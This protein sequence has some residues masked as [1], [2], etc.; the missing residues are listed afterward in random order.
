L[1]YKTNKNKY[2]RLYNILESDLNNIENYELLKTTDDCENASSKITANEYGLLKENDQLFNNIDTEYKMAGKPQSRMKKYY[3]EKKK[4]RKCPAN[5]YKHPDITQLTNTNEIDINELRHGWNSKKYKDK[6]YS[7]NENICRRK[8]TSLENTLSMEDNYSEVIKVDWNSGQLEKQ[9]RSPLWDNGWKIERD[10][11]NNEYL[12]RPD[13]EVFIN[14]GDIVYNLVK[15]ESVKSQEDDEKLKKL[16]FF[17]HELYPIKIPNN[18]EYNLNEIYDKSDE[19]ILDEDYIKYTFISR[20]NFSFETLKCIDNFKIFKKQESISNEFKHTCIPILWFYKI[21][22]NYNNLTDEKENKFYHLDKLFHKKLM[23]ELLLILKRF[24]L[25][26]NN[27]DDE[28]LSFFIIL[29]ALQFITTNIRTNKKHISLIDSKYWLHTKGEPKFSLFD[30]YYKLNYLINDELKKNKE[31]RDLK[32]NVLVGQIPYIFENIVPYWLNKK[33][34]WEWYEINQKAWEK[35]QLFFSLLQ[36][37]PL[38]QPL[39]MRKFP[40]IFP[41]PKPIEISP[42]DKLIYE[43]EEKI[44]FYERKKHVETHG[45]NSPF[46][47]E[48]KDII[49]KK[50]FEADIDFSQILPKD[51]KKKFGTECA[52]SFTTSVIDKTKLQ[53]VQD[54]CQNEEY[55]CL[56]EIFIHGTGFDN[57]YTI[58]DGENPVFFFNPQP[59]ATLTFD[60]NH[61]DIYNMYDLKE[62]WNAQSTPLLEVPN[63]AFIPDE[64]LIV[65]KRFGIS[66]IIE[67]KKSGKRE[68]VFIVNNLDLL[69][70]IKQTKMPYFEIQ[71]MHNIAK[72][73]K[74]IIQPKKSMPIIFSSCRN[75]SKYNNAH[76]ELTEKLIFDLTRDKYDV[77]S[78]FSLDKL[79]YFEDDTIIKPYKASEPTCVKPDHCKLG[80]VL[81]V[82]METI[83]PDLYKQLRMSLKFDLPDQGEGVLNIHIE[84]YLKWAELLSNPNIRDFF[85][86]H[87]MTAIERATLLVNIDE[88]LERE[89]QVDKKNWYRIPKKECEKKDVDVCKREGWWLFEEKIKIK[90]KN[91]NSPGNWNWQLNG[92]YNRQVRSFE[93]PENLP[94]QM[95]PEFAEIIHKHFSTSNKQNGGNGFDS[96]KKEKIDDFINL[97]NENMIQALPSQIDDYSIYDL[98]IFFDNTTSIYDSKFLLSKSLIDNYISYFDKLEKQ[99]EEI[100]KMDNYQILFI[101][102]VS[103]FIWEVSANEINIM[104]NEYFERC[105]LIEK[106][107]NDISEINKQIQSIKNGAIWE[108]YYKFN[109]MNKEE[110]E[111]YSIEKIIEVDDIIILTWF[112]NII[113]NDISLDRDYKS[114]IDQIESTDKFKGTPIVESVDIVS[115][116]ESLDKKNKFYSIK[117]YS[118]SLNYKIANYEDLKT[119]KGEYYI[120]KIKG[121]LLY[122]YKSLDVLI[123]YVQLKNNELMSQ[124]D[125]IKNLVILFVKIE[126]LLNNMDIESK[127]FP[128]NQLLSTKYIRRYENYSNRINIDEIKEILQKISN[129]FIFDLSIINESNSGILLENIQTTLNTLI[130][131]FTYEKINN[132]IFSDIIELKT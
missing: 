28:T 129:S 26:E 74:H 34:Y 71:E 115:E 132:I 79:Q 107:V 87:D 78:L 43:L 103:R 99:F 85:N 56:I 81:K 48:F 91:A 84:S 54:K 36:L 102:Y 60:T 73:L 128:N 21:F 104:Y 118:D 5:F 89:K 66:V 106:Q 33:N 126:N 44:R 22:D 68:K 16:W 14:K 117:Y 46:Y 62:V 51:C 50:M 13:R 3:Q 59:G 113:I 125:H 27:F 25:L 6:Y 65:H 41:S 37:S 55:N 67:N 52:D 111:K 112:R 120:N 100:I 119:T 94:F 123:E 124:L 82:P 130:E 4:S 53:Y 12:Y 96:H 29:G 61:Y 30:R 127:K 11:F 64:K 40:N 116:D 63:L 86:K 92:R 83:N 18:P 38:I 58:I 45:I 98:E 15:D 72:S 47:D 39:I 19:N 122:Y 57:E 20:S 75:F 32:T 24:I 17:H 10:F 131:K 23:E 1:Y 97:N 69:S 108:I 88:F 2:V 35:R 90:L 49:E 77:K 121:N 105:K 114:I 70:L 101:I 42:A 109:N 95:R 110:W 93:H 8:Y 31:N 76:Y 7:E 9:P 80:R